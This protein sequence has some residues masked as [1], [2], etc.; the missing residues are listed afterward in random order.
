MPASPLL[1]GVPSLRLLLV[2]IQC[3]ILLV[4][5]AF[6]ATLEVLLHFNLQLGLAISSFPATF[7]ELV[8]L[9]PQ[10]LLSVQLRVLLKIVAPGIQINRLALLTLDL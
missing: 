8:P 1:I 6:A 5:A 2:L 4:A 10:Q 3:A 7:I 9:P